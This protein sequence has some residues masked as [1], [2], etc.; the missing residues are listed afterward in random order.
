MKELSAIDGMRRVRCDHCQ[1]GVTSVDDAGNVGNARRATG[2]M[3]NN[4]YIAERCF[5]GRDHIRLLNGRAK[6]C[7]KYPPRPVAE[8]LRALRQSM[9][10]AGCGEAQGLTGRDRQLTIAAVE[11]G[12]TLEEPKLLSIFDS[13]DSAQEFRDRRTGLPLNPEMVKKARE[14]EMQ[15]MDELKFL[16]DRDRDTCMAETGRPPILTDWVDIDKGDSIKPNYRSSSVCQETRRRSTIDV[17]DWAA[18]FAATPP[19][20]AFRLQLS[21]MT[22]GPRS[23]VEG[24]DDVLILLDTSQAHLHSPLARVVFVT[25]S[26]KVHKLPKAMYGLRDAGA[27]LDRKVLDVM[28]LMGVSLGKFSICVGHRKRLDTLVRYVRWGDDFSLSGR[29]SLCKTF[30]DDDLEQT[31]EALALWGQREV[32]DGSSMPSVSLRKLS[33]FLSLLLSLAVFLCYS[34]SESLPLSDASF[35]HPSCNESPPFT[36]YTLSILLS[37][38]ALAAP[39]HFFQV[40]LFLSRLSLSLCPFFTLSPLLYFGLFPLHSLST[41]SAVRKKDSA[42]CTPDRVA[43]TIAKASRREQTETYNNRTRLQHTQTH[44]QQTLKI[45]G[46]SCKTIQCLWGFFIFCFFCLCSVF[47]LSLFCLFCLYAFVLFR[48]SCPVFL[49][50]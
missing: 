27:S 22:T 47:V 11:A 29:R 3:T 32:S 17:E 44:M 15:N 36:F 42:R 1:F 2:F 31:A 8:I 20:E 45:V 4:E 40:L 34:L 26:G 24:D 48:V 23:Q 7:E 43:T 46:F 5:G 33:L 16:E 49:L 30:R 13:T 35:L 12:S 38:S 37:C 28:N 18:T 10:A 41:S 50:S 25:I 14:F 19:C 21:L 6:A 39:F 9:R